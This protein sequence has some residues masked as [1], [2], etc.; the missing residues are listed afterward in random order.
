[1]P[2]Q[3][4]P[5]TERLAAGARRNGECIEFHGAENGIGYSKICYDGRRQYAHRVSYQLHKGAIP[6]GLEIDH[7]CRNRKCINPDHLEAVTHAENCRRAVRHR[8]RTR[9]VDNRCKHGHLMD[10]S[11]SY[12]WSGVRSDGRAVQYRQ[13][14]ACNL[15]NHRRS[16]K[17]QA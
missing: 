2:G 11:N 8:P 3:Y 5:I 6:E 7:L 12:L 13:C 15:M 4:R 16:K 1:M 9:R 10:E 17:V 14:R